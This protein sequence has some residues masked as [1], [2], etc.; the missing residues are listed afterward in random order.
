MTITD[1]VAEI[2][3][4]GEKAK[5]AILRELA[6]GDVDWFE[7]SEAIRK[8][9]YKE[10]FVA[11]P[12]ITKLEK[13]GLIEKKEQKFRLL[14][15]ELTLEILSSNKYEVDR[16]L[17]LSYGRGDLAGQLNEQEKYILSKV[18]LFSNSVSFRELYESFFSDIENHLGPFSGYAKPSYAKQ[19]SQV[20]TE[21]LV[22]RD[23]LKVDNESVTLP[24]A[25]FS[26]FLPESFSQILFSIRQTRE[27]NK[28]LLEENTHLAKKAIQFDPSN[29][30]K[31]V[32]PHDG[33]DSY[34]VKAASRIEEG[35]YSEA[36]INCYRVSEYLV[37]SLFVFLYPSQVP[38]RMKHEDKLKK[39]WNDDEK[40]KHCYSGIKAIASL[41]S[42]ILWYRNKMA[43]HTEM[44]PTEDAAR[45]CI[46][47]ILQALKE[48]DR[49]SIPIT[50]Q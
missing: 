46:F 29:L 49:L 11:H 34:V 16:I 41:L 24:E 42:V 44:E 7:L 43:A 45:T 18:L 37:K 40:E 50:I 23:F 17:S 20:I 8:K 28:Q 3:K 5:L 9:Y 2:I 14:N 21:D 12:F 6:S 15:K 1:M 19:R 39:I 4:N 13:D 26:D 38:E 35:S 31:S 33:I 30:L 27:K 47:S 32:K 48:F 22:R 10:N 25:V 36:I